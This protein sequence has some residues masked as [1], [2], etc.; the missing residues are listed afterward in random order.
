MKNSSLLRPWGS[1]G[2]VSQAPLGTLAAWVGVPSQRAF[3]HPFFLGLEEEDAVFFRISDLAERHPVDVGIFRGQQEEQQCAQTEGPGAGRQSRLKR[4]RQATGSFEMLP[5]SPALPPSLIQPR[6]CDPGALMR[7]VPPPPETKSET[8]ARLHLAGKT[9]PSCLR[10]SVAR[11]PCTLSLPLILHH[12]CED[13]P[14]LPGVSPC[15]PP[16]APDPSPHP[17]GRL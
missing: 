12:M 13:D 16:G 5:Q 9:S 11:P 17:Q 4:K 6:G 8:P 1:P 2:A 10:W 14:G 7:T 15:K 3:N